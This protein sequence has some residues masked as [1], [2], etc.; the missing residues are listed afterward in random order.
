MMEQAGFHDVSARPL[1][2]GVASIYRGSKAA[3]N[4]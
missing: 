4:G 3:G 2:A 1:T